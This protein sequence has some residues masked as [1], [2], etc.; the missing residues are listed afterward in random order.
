MMLG[1]RNTQNRWRFP[2]G[3]S[4]SRLPLLIHLESGFKSQRYYTC[5][6]LSSHL[7]IYGAPFTV[8]LT[9]RSLI[10]IILRS[11]VKENRWL[12]ILY[13]GME[14]SVLFEMKP[15]KILQRKHDDNGKKKESYGNHSALDIFIE[16]YSLTNRNYL[17]DV[18]KSY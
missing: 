16:L 2:E 15:R 1:N 3:L 11:S 5:P 17:L 18:V 4:L 9:L 14:S 13:H 8:T 6:V 10:I 12:C 7:V